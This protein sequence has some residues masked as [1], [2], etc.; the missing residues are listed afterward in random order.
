MWRSDLRGSPGGG[1]G[2]GDGVGDDGDDDEEEEDEDDSDY[3]ASKKRKKKKMK[4]SRDSSSESEKKA[5]VS[6]KIEMSYFPT[7]SHLPA[8]KNYVRTAC[9]DASNRKD[10]GPVVRWLMDVEAE[11]RR[12]LTLRCLEKAL[13]FWTESSLMLS[14]GL[15]R[16][17]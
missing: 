10:E 8:W 14:R 17:S 4:K 5:K 1:G 6:Q 15:L 13:S 9:V 12:C 11:G 7:I 2:G 3:E 16:A